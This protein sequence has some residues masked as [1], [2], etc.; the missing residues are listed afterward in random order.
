VTDRFGT[1]IRYIGVLRP[2]FQIIAHP[3]SPDASVKFLRCQSAGLDLGD[4]PRFEVIL[5]MKTHWLAIVSRIGSLDP[6][7]LLVIRTANPEE[8]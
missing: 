7:V 3:V 2:N 1:L 6:K 4:A 8:T 5:L